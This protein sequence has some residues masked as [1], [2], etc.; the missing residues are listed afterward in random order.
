MA[1]LTT[2]FLNVRYLSYSDTDFVKLFSLDIYYYLIKFSSKDTKKIKKSKRKTFVNMK[3]SIK[4]F[5]NFLID[6]R[7]SKQLTFC[8]CGLKL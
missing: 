5:L 8:G 2:H 4:M 1:R 3:G 7:K 6:I